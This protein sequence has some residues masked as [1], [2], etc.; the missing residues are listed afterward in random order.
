MIV[1]RGVEF[2]VLDS[3]G[4]KV[5]GKYKTK[6]M[7]AGAET[8]LLLKS[9]PNG[10]PAKTNNAR[11]F[12]VTKQRAPT[13]ASAMAL[14]RKNGGVVRGA[15]QTVTEWRFKQAEPEAFEEGSTYTEE[16]E[17]GVFVV[18]GK[19]ATGEEAGYSMREA[20]S[21]AVV[22]YVAEANE[23]FGDGLSAELEGLFS[24]MPPINLRPAAFGGSFAY[25]NAG[26]LVGPE[27]QGIECEAFPC[28]PYGTAQ[29]LR[30]GSGFWRA[31][32]G[33]PFAIDVKLLKLIFKNTQTR[34][35]PLRG[36]YMHWTDLQAGQPGMYR[37]AGQVDPADLY[38]GKWKDPITRQPALGIFG[39]VAWEQEA[40]SL[41]QKGLNQISPVID[42]QYTLRHDTPTAPAGTYLGPTIIKFALVDEGFFWMDAVRL[43]KENESRP[44]SFLY[45]ERHAP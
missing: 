19:R 35:R 6:Q 26:A 31:D 3:N 5:L 29:F 13:L 24:L 7:A 28:E 17:A 42:W 16:L 36:D 22:D 25:D 2:W 39:P 32:H 4:Q 27:G 44:P 33:E 23:L 30:T 8:E 43:Y 21:S 18:L 45:R 12:I 20:M 37:P 40:A 11:L 41:I 15:R 14:V 9:S 10:I 1:R 38:I 34:C